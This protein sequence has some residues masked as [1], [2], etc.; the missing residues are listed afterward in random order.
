MRSSVLFYVSYALCLCSGLLC[1]LFVSVWSSCWRGGFSWDGSALQFNWH[2]VLMVS[3]LLVLYGYAAVVYRVP[4]TWQQKKLTWKLVHAALMLLALILSI[5]GLC[6]VF[7]FHRQSHI[8]D[9]YSL[10]SWVGI[11]T[12]IVFSLQWTLGLW[13]FLFPCSP[14]WF[15]GALK[16]VHIWM[17]KAILI[18][19]VAS[20]ISGINEKLF[21]TLNGNSSEPYSSLPAE[22]KFANSL[23]VL[24]LVFGL[25]VFGILSK[26][27]WKRPEIETE[28]VHL[29]PHENSP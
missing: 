2:P 8:P 6:A 9:L 5:L 15:P 23:G 11:C 12:V 29:L 27:K 1:L 14:L 18:L 25:V 10:H 3:G 22:A 21:F 26:K 7:D 24:I 4:F 13:G 28:S 19:S 16:P 17:G 20:C